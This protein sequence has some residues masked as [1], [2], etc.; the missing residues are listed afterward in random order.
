[1]KDFMTVQHY[2]NIFID[3]RIFTDNSWKYEWAFVALEQPF[4]SPSVWV[5]FG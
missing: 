4:K 5:F 1:M 3:Q 2:S